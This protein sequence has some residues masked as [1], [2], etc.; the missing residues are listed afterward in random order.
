MCPAVRPSTATASPLLICSWKV[1]VSVIFWIFWGKVIGLP[2]NPHNLEGQWFS[3]RVFL[4]LGDLYGSPAGAALV[5]TLTAQTNPAWLDLPGAQDSHCRSHGGH[6]V[7]QA[8]PPQQGTP[9]RE[10][11]QSLLSGICHFELL[12]SCKCPCRPILSIKN[13]TQC[14]FGILAWVIDQACFIKMTGYCLCSVFSSLW[15]DQDSVSRIYYLKKKT[16][17]SCT[18]SG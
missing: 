18:H 3:V 6:K 2:P 15:M 11:M 10:R 8:S 9:P 14:S 16:L 12:E 7:T 13:I 1:T 5:W 4:P 17:F